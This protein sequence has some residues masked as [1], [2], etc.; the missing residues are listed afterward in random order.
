M[1][2]PVPLV[3]PISLTRLLDQ[4]MRLLRRHL[5]VLIA[6]FA[7]PLAVAGAV[8]P[9]MQLVTAYSVDREVG[10]PTSLPVMLLSV[11]VM[12]LSLVVLGLTYVAMV[13]AA[14]D[15]VAG[16]PVS[17]GRA[18][19]AALEPRLIGTMILAT[20][21]WVG[22]LLFCILPGIYIAL[23][24]SVVIP[25]MANEGRFGT[26]ALGRSV[27]IMRFN[28]SRQLGADPRLRSFVLGLTGALI[29]WVV[30]FVVQLPLMVLM[31]VAMLRG[32]ASG[33]EAD[34]DALFR[35]MAWLQVPSNIVAMVLRGLVQQYLGFGIALIYFDVVGRKEG[36]DLLTAS[37]E[38]AE[39]VA[40]GVP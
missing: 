20:L 34:P 11:G 29:G 7:I 33:A 36:E 5:R 35:Q 18:W 2:S 37:E 17:G 13:V 1:S 10:S 23:I 8:T 3:E 22:G 9:L 30:G 19:R 6:P 27:Q 25:V 12:L 24:L 16:R 15:A 14:T 39:A 21:A 28:P 26:A 38:L 40:P 31:M 4:A 32:A